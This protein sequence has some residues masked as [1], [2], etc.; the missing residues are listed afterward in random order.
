MNVPYSVHK[1]RVDFSVRVCGFVVDNLCSYVCVNKKKIYQV[2]G[3]PYSRYAI[4]LTKRK[5]VCFTVCF[6]CPPPPLMTQISVGVF[7]C[8]RVLPSVFRHVRE[9]AR[10]DY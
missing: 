4:K 5:V 3:Y 6:N 1:K 8:M 9:I 10:S 2:S 7:F